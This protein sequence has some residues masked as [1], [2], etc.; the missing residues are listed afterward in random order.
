M[1]RKP[2][3]EYLEQVIQKYPA[4]HYEFEDKFFEDWLIKKY[5]KNDELNA[6]FMKLTLLDTLY[7]TNIRSAEARLKIAK[8][9][10]ESEHFD[11]RLKK[12]DISLVVELTK[13]CKRLTGRECYSFSTKYCSLHNRDKFPIFDRIISDKLCAYNAECNFFGSKVSK[14]F[15]KNYANLVQVIDKFRVH[16]K[17]EKFNYR[18]ID[19]F[20]WTLGKEGK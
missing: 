16:F 12:G 10:Y 4:K 17:L 5:P 9:I 19:R 14:N 7:S 2:S 15:L 1:S 11:E 13:E 3:P 18:A 8:F 20:L 6:V